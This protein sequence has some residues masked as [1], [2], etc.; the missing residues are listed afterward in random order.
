MGFNN[1][2]VVMDSTQDLKKALAPL[3]EELA[4]R[5]EGGCP[6]AYGHIISGFR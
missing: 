3:G 2:S 1:S 6:Y 5:G 4:G